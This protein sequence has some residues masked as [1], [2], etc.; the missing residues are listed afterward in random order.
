[1]L[2][3]AHHV[4]KG[5]TKHVDQN[6]DSITGVVIEDIDTNSYDMD[7][8]NNMYGNMN[9]NN[10]NRMRYNGTSG[11]GSPS[12]NRNGIY[13]SPPNWNNRNNNNSSGRSNNRAIQM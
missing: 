10:N 4:A 11:Y 9:M 7:N 5:R 2:S 6:W 8:I 3:A 12:P 1:M 13:T